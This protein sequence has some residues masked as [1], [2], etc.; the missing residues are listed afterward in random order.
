MKNIE[1]TVLVK[2]GGYERVKVPIEM[3][4]QLA[5]TIE[6]KGSVPILLAGGKLFEIEGFFIKGKKTMER[7]IVC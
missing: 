7:I 2:S 3:V 4:G 5:E 6:Q 1:V